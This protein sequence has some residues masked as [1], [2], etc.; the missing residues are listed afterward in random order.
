MVPTRS[1]TNV[2]KGRVVGKPGSLSLSKTFPC[3]HKN[4]VAASSLPAELGAGKVA[5]SYPAHK[6]ADIAAGARKRNACTL[7]KYMPNAR[8]RARARTEEWSDVQSDRV[9]GVSGESSVVTSGQSSGTSSR[10]VLRTRSGRVPKCA[11]ICG[12][13][14]NVKR[15]G[16]LRCR[17]VEHVN[18][19]PYGKRLGKDPVKTMKEE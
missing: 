9:D 14:T 5:S 6:A 2:E 4:E 10:L 17:A 13:W 8:L 19:R 3:T 1:T 18:L 15:R 16:P 7:V 11:S 12:V